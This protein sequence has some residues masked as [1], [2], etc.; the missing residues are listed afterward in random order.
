MAGLKEKL[1]KVNKGQQ[2]VH[3]LYLYRDLAYYI[4]YGIMRPYKNYF[5][6]SQ[7]LVQEKFNKAIL[8]L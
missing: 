5:S 1:K 6:R 4:I 2:P 8:R 3:A 7:T